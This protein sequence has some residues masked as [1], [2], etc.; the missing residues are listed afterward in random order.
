MFDTILV[1]TSK[2]LSENLIEW[3]ESVEYDNFQ[4]AQSLGLNIGFPIKGVPVKLEASFTE[5]KFKEWKK[6][7]STGSS[8]QFT[9]EE[10]MQILSKSASQ[11]I[12]DAWSACMRPGAGKSPGLHHDLTPTGEP[13][14][15]FEV[16][17]IPNSMTD[18][19]PTVLPGGFQ[20]AGAT[21]S[22]TFSDGMEIPLAG[23]SIILTRTSTSGATIVLNTTKG[24]ITESIPPIPVTPPP[25]PKLPSINL[26]LFKASGSKAD[27]AQTT[28]TVPSDYKILGGG[29]RV[30]WTGGGNLLTASFPKDE[31]TWVAKSKA[32]FISDP[33]NIDVW[34]IA[35]H[36]PR[37]EWEVDIVTANGA[38]SDFPSAT[39]TVGSKYVLTGGGAEVNWGGPGNL[40]TASCPQGSGNWIA[41]GKAHGAP[42][43]ASITAY[44][45]GIRARNGVSG[46][47]VKISAGDSA[48]AQHPSTGVSVAS[49]YNLVGGGAQANWKGPGSLLTASFPDGNQWKVASKDHQYV[50]SCTITAYAIGIKP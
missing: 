18:F 5:D 34:V 26:K 42:D 27:I 32:H 48:S 15:V 2:S 1:S 46:P 44:A 14:F 17:W 12:L 6:E 16:K 22:I 36:D 4:K 20:V 21:Y 13:N 3:L 39:A 50:E 35:L 47:S 19:P 10:T 7:I 41:K 31:R 38:P 29:A 30:N 23:F 40:L 28:L 9:E 24:T 37:D 8:R 11:A 49:G 25:A 45:I 33:A 43:P